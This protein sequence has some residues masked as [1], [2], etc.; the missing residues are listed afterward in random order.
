[1]RAYLSITQG[2]GGA[3][4]PPSILPASNINGGFT[5][6]GSNIAN[7]LTLDA[8]PAMVSQAYPTDRRLYKGG[9]WKVEVDIKGFEVDE[10]WYNTLKNNAELRDAFMCE[11][12]CGW[13][14]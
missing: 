11:C 8:V 7:E 1:M 2:Q 12:G 6:S 4:I 14:K 13:P 5:N 10:D 3:N 9:D